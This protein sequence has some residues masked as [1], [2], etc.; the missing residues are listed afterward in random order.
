MLDM[1]SSVYEDDDL[2]EVRGVSWTEVFPP[3]PDVSDGRGDHY[4]AVA[5][6]SYEND[7]AIRTHGLS[8]V[9]RSRPVTRKTTPAAVAQDLIEIRHA[10][11]NMLRIHGVPKDTKISF[12]TLGKYA[13]TACFED[14]GSFRRPKIVLDKS[15]YEK[16][17]A[18]SIIDVYCGIGLHEASHIKHT[19][20][21]F[22]RMVRGELKGIRWV[23][24]G[25]LEDERIETLVGEDSPGFYLY[26]HAAKMAIIHMY[27]L[28]RKAEQFDELP[29]LDKVN[30]IIFLT[31]R[32]PHL[33]SDSMRKW[34][35]VGGVNVFEEVRNILHSYAAD[36]DQ[37]EEYGKKLMELLAKIYPD[38]MKEEEEKDK[39][40][41]EMAKD[42]MEKGGGVPIIFIG[43][44]SGGDAID[45]TPEEL[46]ELLKKAIKIRLDKQDKA[47]EED[48]EY[49]KAK[50]ELSRLRKAL[51]SR[52]HEV[53]E[54]KIEDLEKREGTDRLDTIE[55]EKAAID[56]L[57]KELEEKREDRFGVLDVIRMFEK[58]EKHEEDLSVEETK[59]VAKIV[60]DRMEL[61][62]EWS[63][64]HDRY[65]KRRTVITH[66]RVNDR[67]S[68]IHSVVHDM[69]KPHV[70]RMKSVFSFRLGT[71]VHHI[72]ELTEG[73]LHRRRLGT[74]INTDKIF[75]RTEVKVDRGLALCLLLDESGS[76][77]GIHLRGGYKTKANTALLT[78]VLI[79]EALKGVKG[80]ELEIY[81]FTSTGES[82]QDNL[83]K[84]LYG[85]KNPHIEAISN[86]GEQMAENYDHIAIKTAADMFIENT[87]NTN[88]M[89][90]VLSDG[91]P[92]GRAYGGRDAINQTAEEVRKAEK[93]GIYMMQ[94]AIDA[95]DSSKMYKHYVKFTDIET[96]ITNMRTLITRIIARTTESS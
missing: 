44:S 49:M 21:A 31:I 16:V 76:M 12:K 88:R 43:G 18:E 25:L 77:E 69:V 6:A 96:L 89:M 51:E 42:L 55:E 22:T 83:V 29:D 48:N 15:I 93:R 19:R 17:P 36:E 81:S 82:H 70:A 2:D 75:T 68:A 30:D 38:Y 45:C 73:R 10:V 84:Y 28:R 94:V 61:G 86:Y 11:K 87:V 57:E 34:L 5:R 80:I 24:E 23:W 63:S 20:N 1:E 56:A 47:S 59:E 13:G 37:I 78:S 50:G 4:D 46:E 64:G 35:T 7:Q 9:W 3:I 72:N 32:A 53:T 52:A 90:I 40:I 66:P 14:I 8:E 92:Q 41:E 95:V 65:A 85:K 91:D 60:G 79:A 71:R 54:D 62:S 33:L 74:A 26:T 58:V 27:G 39:C 67:A